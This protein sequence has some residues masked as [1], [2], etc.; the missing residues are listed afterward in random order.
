MVITVQVEPSVA[1]ALHS[2]ASGP[3]ADLIQLVRGYGGRLEPMHPG[4][5]D[6]QLQSFFT[7]DVADSGKAQELT[8]RL[9]QHPSVLAAYTKPAEGLP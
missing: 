6:S 2:G 1:R 5:D 7:A 3:A 9:L 8:E 4:S